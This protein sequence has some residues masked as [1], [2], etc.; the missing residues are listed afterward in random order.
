MAS[1]NFL[2]VSAQKVGALRLHLDTHE[3]LTHKHSNED[4][5]RQLTHNNYFIGT[6]NYDEMRQ[7]MSDRVREVDYFCPPKRV[8]NDR[9]VGCMLEAT[10]P[11]ELTDQGASDNFFKNLYE[12]IAQFFGKENVCGM[13]VHKDEIH[14]YIDKDGTVRTSCEH[15]HVLVAA[16]AEWTNAK[17]EF[18][19]G[20]NAK[21]FETREMLRKFNKAVNDMCLCEFGIEY[22]TH[23][24]QKHLSVEELKRRSQVNEELKKRKQLIKEHNELI[25]TI[26]ELQNGAIELAYEMVERNERSSF[27]ERERE[28]S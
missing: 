19:R 23:G 15:A 14:D 7:K 4:I 28:R 11:R 6:R 8:V 26:N 5:D 24:E 18:R 22:N 21:N 25:D 1:V 13:A 12:L 10:C 9:K 20:I 17:G 2:K 3:R 16:Y 27:Q